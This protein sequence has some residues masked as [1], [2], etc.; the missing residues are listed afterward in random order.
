MNSFI[1]KAKF[2]EKSKQWWRPGMSGVA[3]VYVGERRVIWILTRRMVEFL[4][5]YFWI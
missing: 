5:I 3:K 1:I 2:D 4:R